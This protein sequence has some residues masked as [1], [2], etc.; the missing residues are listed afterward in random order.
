MDS[1]ALVMIEERNALEKQLQ[2]HRERTS[3]VNF[4]RRL[5]R[6]VSFFGPRKIADVH[7]RIDGPRKV[8]DGTRKVSDKHAKVHELSSQVTCYMQ[9]ARCIPLSVWRVKN[10]LGGKGGLKV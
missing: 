2:E 8:S 5:S 1:S 9:Y 3:S 6:N 4:L 10:I 7:A